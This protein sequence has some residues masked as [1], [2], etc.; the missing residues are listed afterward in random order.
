MFAETCHAGDHPASP[1][2]LPSRGLPP[3]DYQRHL[4]ALWT[5]PEYEYS[6]MK[7]WAASGQDKTGFIREWLARGPGAAMDVPGGRVMGDTTSIYVIEAFELFRE[8]GDAAF[9]AEAWPSLRRAI[10]WMTGNAYQPAAVSLL[11][12]V[13]RQVPLF[14]AG[15]KLHPMR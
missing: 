14:A 7:I 9:V 6:K 10:L 3:V 5:F 1:V 11:I 13:P 2:T 4:L 15:V 12:A 8:T